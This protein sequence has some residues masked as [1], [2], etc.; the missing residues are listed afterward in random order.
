MYLETTTPAPLVAL[1]D[2]Y[3]YPDGPISCPG[4]AYSKRYLRRQ[5][6]PQDRSAYFSDYQ[7]G[8]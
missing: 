5:H 4:A 2:F 8:K 6:R 1:V 3:F 7:F